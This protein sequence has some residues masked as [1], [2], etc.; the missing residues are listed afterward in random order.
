M[1]DR[2]PELR[3]FAKGNPYFDDENGETEKPTHLDEFF[4]QCEEIRRQLLQMHDALNVLKL[5]YEGKIDRV[6]WRRKK[7]SNDVSNT[8]IDKI[9][10]QAKNIRLLLG[11]LQKII[12][13]KAYPTENRIK[14]NL[15]QSLFNFFMTN[16]QKYQDIQ[17]RFTNF[18]T[19]NTKNQLLLVN[20]QATEEDINQANPDQIF[21]LS[22]R[23]NVAL[24]YVQDRHQKI[25][26]LQ[27]SLE[28]VQQMFID[29]SVLVNQQSEVVDRIAFNIHNA[30]ED[31]L[32]ATQELKQAQ[33]ISRRKCSLI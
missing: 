2:L 12:P 25:L 14:E 30:K 26:Q 27:R 13:D 9:N 29:L 1:E 10:Y 23:G 8:L 6:S 24:A 18:I 32:V 28:E 16:M 22:S 21:S 7:Q 33:K 3:L 20:P 11:G 19:H 15:Y 31:V 5:E 4:I 17:N